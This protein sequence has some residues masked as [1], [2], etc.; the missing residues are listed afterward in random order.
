M[1]TVERISVL[2]KSADRKS[3][4]SPCMGCRKRYPGC[5]GHCDDYFGWKQ[6]RNTFRKEALAATEGRR[7]SE[8]TLVK[9]WKQ[10]TKR[11]CKMNIVKKAPASKNF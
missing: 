3:G 1:P 5:S 10:G 9:D 2:I 4:N 11:R 6:K 8:N 7:I